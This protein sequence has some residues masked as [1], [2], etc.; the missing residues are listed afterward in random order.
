V[1]TRCVKLAKVN[2]HEPRCSRY[3]SRGVLTAAGA[4]GANAYSFRGRIGDRTLP[5]GRYRLNV[6][7]SRDGKRSAAVTISFTIAR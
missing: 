1:T 6:T 5:P 2:R 3:R 4:A 7:A